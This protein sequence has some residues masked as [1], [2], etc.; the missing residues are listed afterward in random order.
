LR[1]LTFD[2]K[3]CRA[4]IVIEIGINTLIVFAKSYPRTSNDGVPNSNNPIPKIDWTIIKTRI[5]KISINKLI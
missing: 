4:L 3:N 2:L 1:S 5:I